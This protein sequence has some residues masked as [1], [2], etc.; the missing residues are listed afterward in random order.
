MVTANLHPIWTGGRDGPESRASVALEVARKPAIAADPGEGAFDDPSLRPYNE[1]M[2]IAAL[3]DLSTAPLSKFDVDFISILPLS[4]VTRC[5][6]RCSQVESSQVAV[7]IIGAISVK[8][9]SCVYPV[10]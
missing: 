4:P 6:N 3:D 8:M 10:N 2:R 1:A 5:W 7:L 9:R